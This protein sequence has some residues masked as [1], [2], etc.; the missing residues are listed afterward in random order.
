MKTDVFEGIPYF[1]TNQ[2]QVVGWS[3]FFLDQW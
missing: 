2:F 1:Q 3:S